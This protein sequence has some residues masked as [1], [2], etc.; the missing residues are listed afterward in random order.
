[1]ICPKCN[2]PTPDNTRFC[3]NCGQLLGADT[4]NPQAT[5]LRTPVGPPAAGAAAAGAATA[6][7]GAAAAPRGGDKMLPAFV[8]RVKNILLTPKT[9][10]PA[11]EREPTTIAHLY[12]AYVMPLAALAA[13]ISFVRMSLIGI[14]LPFGGAIRTPLASGLG[15]A[16]VTFGFGLLGSYL[17]ALIINALAPTFSGERDQRQALK[18]AAYAFTP[19]WLGAVLSLLG[20]FATL[21]QLLAGIYGIYL[22]ALGLPMLMKSPREKAAGYTAAVVICTILVGI[23]FGVLS[24]ATGGLGGFGRFGAMNSYTGMTGGATREQQQLQAAAAVGN[25]LGGVLGTDQQGKA[26]LGSAINHLAEAG[27][28][29]ERQPSAAPSSGLQAAAASSGA[30]ASSPA[31][32]S[33]GDNPQN[34]V[35]A[36]AGL[37]TALGGALGGG[38]RVDPVDFHMLKGML[39]DSLP[40]MQRT[41]AEGSSKQ[42]MGVKGSSAKA[43]YRAP[44]GTRAEI[45]ISDISGVAGLV[46]IA[47]SVAENSESDAGYEK[48]AMVG[49]RR[50]HEKYDV[51]SK[52]GEVSAI[53]A[54]RFAVD[55]TGD[56]SDMSSLERYLAAVDLGRLEAMK[57]MGATSN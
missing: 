20:G 1:M 28:N 17:V 13:L 7:L 57:N 54:K 26:D 3:G 25:L 2:R 52:H 21:L 35:A 14:S 27:Q 55:V 19:A 53:V 22:L 43:I 16:F 41:D 51:R 8:E 11:I 24:A 45:T 39:P 46:D 44:S 18:A 4:G 48:D 10:W 15:Y 32:G 6:D 49:G 34:A 50:V 36:T 40:G 30:L 33:A 38:R 29:I 42:A 56:G 47:D 5:L 9:E 37:L 12:T 23:V 31:S